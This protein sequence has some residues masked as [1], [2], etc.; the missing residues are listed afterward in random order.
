MLQKQMFSQ[1]LASVNVKE[2][3]RIMSYALFTVTKLPNNELTGIHSQ[4]ATPALVTLNEHPIVLPCK[5]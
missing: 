2:Y 3:I 1:S 4:P 5:Q